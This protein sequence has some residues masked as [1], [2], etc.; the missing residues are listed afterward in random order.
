MKLTIII[1]CYNEENTI[2]IIIDKVKKTNLQKIKKEII[3]IDDGSKDNSLQILRSINNINLIVN[4]TN[5]GKGSAIHEGLLKS[6]GDYIIIQDAD[7]EYD[8]SDYSK[9]LDKAIKDNELVVYGSRILNK[10]NKYSTLSFYLGGLLVTFFTNLLFKNSHLTDQ[11]TCYKLFKSEIIKNINLK[12]KGFEF[13]SEVTAK[14]LKKNIKIAE[15]PINYYPRKKKDGKKIKW[16]DG[17]IAL[18]TLIKYKLIN[19]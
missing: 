13:C 2:S 15:I 19:D 1:P 11:P 17:L 10:K 16:I 4:K 14:I 12:S 7:L 8:P 18:K 9:L 5:L 3:V 6:T